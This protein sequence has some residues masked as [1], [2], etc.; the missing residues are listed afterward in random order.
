MPPR[1]PANTEETMRAWGMSGDAGEDPT[2]LIPVVPQSGG[3]ARQVWIIGVTVA[4]GVAV[5]IA[6]GFLLLGPQKAT[7]PPLVPITSTTTP[8]VSPSPS[9]APTET[10][11][12]TVTATTYVPV[13]AITPTTDAPPSST[14]A[15]PSHV[16]RTCRQ[17]HPHRWCNGYR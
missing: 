10:V 6:L 14:P 5:L 7:T 9:A 15:D 12:E 1:E 13:P 3:H 8:S 11:T 16:W 2:R 17:M 4:A